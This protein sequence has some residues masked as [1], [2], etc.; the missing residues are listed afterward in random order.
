MNEIE[1]L[2]SGL[3]S[4]HDLLDKAVDEMTPEQWNYWPHEGGVSAFFLFGIT[5]G[6]KIT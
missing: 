3:K 5:F 1:I 4:M 2:I 6:L